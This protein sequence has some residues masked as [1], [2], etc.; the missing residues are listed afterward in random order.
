M[1]KQKSEI[2]LL[3]IQKRSVIIKYKR[4]YRKT[5]LTLVFK[6]DSHAQCTILDNTTC[7]FS[8]CNEVHLNTWTGSVQKP[9]LQEDMQILLLVFDMQLHLIL[10]HRWSHTV[11]AIV[12]LTWTCYLTLWANSRAH[13]SRNT[14]CRDYLSVQMSPCRSRT[15]KM[16]WYLLFPPPVQCLAM[17]TFKLPVT[18]CQVIDSNIAKLALKKKTQD[19]VQNEWYSCLLKPP[20]RLLFSKPY[21][22]CFTNTIKYS[23]RCGA[24]L[25]V[26]SQAYSKVCQS[27]DRTMGLCVSSNLAR[28]QKKI[29]SWVRILE[30]FRCHLKASAKGTKLK[31]DLLRGKMAHFQACSSTW[32]KFQ[33]VKLSCASLDA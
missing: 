14:T 31:N 8:I 7:D 18:K 22:K 19:N 11:I 4:L 28:I 17:H 32:S 21:S 25:S 6:A 10:W 16:I 3:C 23:G 20:Q 5:C 12:W 26:I 24:R 29:K 13:H 27:R 1:E 30:K 2:Y 33:N 15:A 9:C